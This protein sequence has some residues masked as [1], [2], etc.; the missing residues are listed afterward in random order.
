[1][2][3]Y[4]PRDARTAHTDEADPC[5]AAQARMKNAMLSKRSHRIAVAVAV[6]IT[7]LTIL[8]IGLV[9]FLSQSPEEVRAPVN[10]APKNNDYE[11]FE[12]PWMQS[13]KPVPNP[14]HPL[15]KSMDYEDKEAPKVYGNPI[16]KPP[17]RRESIETLVNMDSPKF[18]EVEP[19]RR[20]Q[21]HNSG[22]QRPP[23]PVSG[24]TRGRTTIVTT[25]RPT[26]TSTSTTTTTTAPSTTTEVPAPINAIPSESAP[27]KASPK[28]TEST[29][30]THTDRVP[31][32]L[33]PFEAVDDQ[34]YD[35]IETDDIF[36]DC[37]QYRAKGHKSG[38]YEVKVGSTTFRALCLME[39]GAA[40]M[41]LQR[42]S[43]GNVDFNRTFEEYATG[44]G[45]PASDHWLG[46]E[47]VHAY[48]ARG[49][50]LELRIELRGDR[51][52]DSTK[53]SGYGDQGYWWADW[54]FS[55]GPRADGYRLSLPPAL[56][57][58]LTAG[59]DEFSKMNDGQKFTTIDQDNDIKEK[60]NCA[61]FRDL[62]AWWHKDCTFAALNGAYVTKKTGQRDM[63]WFYHRSKST[64]SN[65]SV[66]YFI[67]PEKSLMKF[68]IK[69]D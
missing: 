16:V 54:D 7:F 10:S 67:K 51:C 49:D 58:N 27:E 21:F 52:V 32:S 57:G 62:G 28:S 26:T 9:I 47:H 66:T 1:M 5:L 40:W 3:T 24:V 41:V 53:C 2:R 59:T 44:F 6:L 25:R 8:A 36:E 69:K 35:F 14:R 63:H 33:T 22:E 39:P 29:Y 64:K 46:L 4:N 48:V 34:K 68:R 38:V 37:E 12:S 60:F 50:K 65:G 43:N 20:S 30:T 18:V 42:R 56:E 61:K 19:V 31:S 23:A 11:T 45:N 13:T 15:S 17:P 55:V